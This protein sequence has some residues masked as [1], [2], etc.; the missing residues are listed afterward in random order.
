[1]TGRPPGDGKVPVKGSPERN[2]PTDGMNDV[3]M[4]PSG[5]VSTLLTVTVEREGT[6]DGVTV[7]ETTLTEANLVVK[8]LPSGPVLVE[9]TSTVD[10]E[11]DTEGASP[12]GV[13]GTDIVITEGTTLV[14]GRPLAPFPV[15]LTII[16]D[17][18]IT[19][20]GK[21]FPDGVG[22]KVP[23]TTDVNGVPSGEVPVAVKEKISP[24]LAVGGL[25]VLPKAEGVTRI[26]E[27]NGIPDLSIPV[28]VKENGAGAQLPEENGGGTPGASDEDTSGCGEWI[29]LGVEVE[30]TTEVKRDPEASVPVVVID[31]TT[32]A[33]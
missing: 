27:V 2:V 13:T 29:R 14:K 4:G 31:T 8:R 10:V 9:V 11:V 24:N 17:S 32:G 12:V 5:F 30:T 28:V 6:S 1:V 26:T 21:T 23:T 3:K 7:T 18:D 20:G 33:G 25:P 16:V 15:L 19:T 22:V